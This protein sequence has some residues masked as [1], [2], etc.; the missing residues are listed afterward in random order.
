MATRYR[1][2]DRDQQFLLPPD[3]RE[4]LPDH[5]LVW[6]IEALVG[7]L[8][9]SAFTKRRRRAT[10]TSR[11]GQPGYDPDMLLV[12][13]LY[14]YSVG[15][16]SSRGIEKL[17]GTDIAFRVA[18]A[19]DIPDH[20]V[21][22]RFRADNIEAFS[23]LFAQVLAECVRAGMGNVGVIAIDGTK[24]AANASIDANRKEPYLRRLIDEITD[25]AE[26]A[27]NDDALLGDDDD[28]DETARK[29]VIYNASR[30]DRA[31][32]CVESFDEGKD[33]VTSTPIR[34]AEDVL[35]RRQHRYQRMYDQQLKKYEGW[36]A[37]P[38]RD[39][40]KPCMHPDELM[41][42]K[43]RWAVIEE[44]KTRI[45]ALKDKTFA[46]RTGQA[47]R[48]NLTDPQSRLMKARTGFVQG[49]NTQFAVSDDHV[50]VAAEVFTDAV[51]VHLFEPM[52]R[53]TDRE[54]KA[55]TGG[56][57]SV[58]VVLAD[59]GYHSKENLAVDGPDRLISDRKARK[60]AAGVV[61]E[62]S[63]YPLV[64]AMREKLATEENMQLYRRRAALVETINAWVKEWLGMRRLSMRGHVKAIGE[65]KLIAAVIN[66]LRLHSR[67]AGALP[68][69]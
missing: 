48:R 3:M 47:S 49:Y 61:S 46:Q 42:L 65:V 40:R 14:A 44:S 8:E 67:Q 33:N 4:W 59:A 24:I 28:D 31:K 64:Q 22:S 11:A 63:Q 20:T 9:T 55:A 69:G 34:R 53:A 27:D 52:L 5:H 36:R 6:V 56:Q 18:C 43:K 58:G 23:D 19:G 39:R 32:E 54:L 66:I 21:I 2:V 45:Q 50:I 15:Q 16:R 17:C 7:D 60:L 38:D 51:D 68:A 41:L 25:E 37:S 1:P 62:T 57:G 30:L 35:D 26:A 12:L 29:A 10:T 13:L